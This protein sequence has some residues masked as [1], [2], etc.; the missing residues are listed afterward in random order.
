VKR[1]CH[2]GKDVL[3]TFRPACAEDLDYCANL[4]FSGM[5]S[6]IR[7]LKLDRAAQAASLRQEWELAQVRVIVLDAVDVGWFQ[8]IPH[9]DVLFLAQ[10]FVD[11][12]FQGR[13]IGTEVMNRLIGEGTRAGQAM[14]LAVVKTNP[15]LRLYRRLGFR[16]THEDDRKFYMRRD[17][18]P[19]HQRLSS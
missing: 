19:G 15:A 6:I 16:I 18:V 8:I 17:P 4:Y 3:I 2:A 14:A 10:L 12:P 5:E 1:R 7:E 13:G 9:K 11:R